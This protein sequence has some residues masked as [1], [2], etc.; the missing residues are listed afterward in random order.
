MRIALCLSGQ[1][2]FYD[3]ESYNS[4]KREIIDSTV[5]IDGIEVKNQVDVF[6]HTWAPGDSPYPH[7][8]WSNLKKGVKT[9]IKNQEF[10][11]NR[12]INI[13]FDLDLLYEPKSFFI[14]QQ[15]TFE[16][17]LNEHNQ[18]DYLSN[19]MPSMFYSM[20]E[21]NELRQQYEFQ[22]NIKY[23]F[24]VRARTDTL[25]ERKSSD[26]SVIDF[27]LLKKDTLYIP[28]NC[29][30]PRLYNDNFS[31][32]GGEI[33]DAVYD[34]FDRLSEY[35]DY[36]IEGINRGRNDFSPERIWTEHLEKN[37]ITV[38]LL[39]IEQNFVRE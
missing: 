9:S 7:S 1:P 18:N 31:V 21:S 2:R 14:Q 28:D 32:C 39:N 25:L 24:V 30:N 29:G 36:S 10:K 12:E 17:F 5:L 20:N 23:D 6:I 33:S 38:E 13:Y 11:E 34:V 8:T 35:V 4:L 22:E 19:N 15:L 26:V 16:E 37:N 3:S 27:S